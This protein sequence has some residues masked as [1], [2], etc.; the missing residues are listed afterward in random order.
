[1]FFRAP[2]YMVYPPIPDVISPIFTPMS[3]RPIPTN[4]LTP[5]TSE[6]VKAGAV[7]PKEANVSS[8]P[9]FGMMPDFFIG[10]CILV[11]TPTFDH[12]TLVASA[13]P[14]RP[15][16][17]VEAKSQRFK[18]RKNPNRPLNERFKFF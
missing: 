16:D 9:M 6:G 5:N 18:S 15:V 1:M 7:S 13:L 17:T 14:E 2:G 10:K 4:Q 3:S 8:P 11:I 12:P